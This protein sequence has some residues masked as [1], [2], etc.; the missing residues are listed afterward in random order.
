LGLSSW[1]TPF[2][3]DIRPQFGGQFGFGGSDGSGFVHLA[4][5]A[6]GLI[7]VKTNVRFYVGGTAGAMFGEHGS[8]FATADFGMQLMF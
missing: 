3:G 4:A 6:R 1:Y 8:T 7:E 2:A 5:Q